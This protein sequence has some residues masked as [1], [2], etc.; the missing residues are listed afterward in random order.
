MRTTVITDFEPLPGATL[1]L[2]RGAFD[3]AAGGTFAQEN[4][5]VQA[6]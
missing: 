6:K 4:F 3:E 5:R 1:D 2:I